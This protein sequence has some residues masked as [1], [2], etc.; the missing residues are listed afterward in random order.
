MD[1][2]SHKR[3]R[4][5]DWLDQ[6]FKSRA[7]ETGG[8]IRRQ[9]ADVEREVGRAALIS[10]VRRRNFRLIRTRAHFVIVCDPGPVQ[11]IV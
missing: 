9:I 7:V 6:V 3:A 10:E 11:Q 2:T 5:Q 4:G 1:M 8:V